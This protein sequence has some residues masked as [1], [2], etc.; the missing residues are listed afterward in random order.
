MLK[1]IFAAKLSCS[2]LNLQKNHSNYSMLL[3]EKLGRPGAQISVALARLLSEKQL[4]N[5][6][7]ERGLL[8]IESLVAGGCDKQQP[9]NSSSLVITSLFERAV[10][11]R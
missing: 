3:T 10:L 7:F 9:N 4:D 11:V 5:F 8:K 6:R 1:K 2:N